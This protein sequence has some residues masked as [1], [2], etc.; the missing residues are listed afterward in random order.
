MMEEQF[1]VNPSDTVKL[2][3][4]GFWA[5]AWAGG[6]HGRVQGT[7]CWDEEAF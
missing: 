7:V 6:W 1:V 5:A 2:L 3:H 4:A